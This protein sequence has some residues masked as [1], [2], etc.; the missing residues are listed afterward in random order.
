MGASC[1]AVV[2]VSLGASV[3]GADP[4]TPASGPAPSKNQTETV[5]V[6]SNIADPCVT[7]AGAKFEQWNQPRFM[8]RRTETF[9]DGS[10][11]EIEA[12]FTEDAAYGHDVGLPWETENLV[13][14][15]TRIASAG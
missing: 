10:K 1:V 11:K 4:L 13:R 14:K 12:I 6:D 9:S 15:E 2:W 8:I 7:V 3:S 5:A